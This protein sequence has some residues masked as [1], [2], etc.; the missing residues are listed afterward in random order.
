[1]T[2]SGVRIPLAA[3]NSHLAEK[4]GSPKTLRV[5]KSIAALA[6]FIDVN[7]SSF[8]R[9]VVEV[10]VW[11]MGG[12]SLPPSDA[13][14]KSVTDFP[15]P[16]PASLRLR[17]ALALPLYAASLVLDYASAALGQLAAWVAGDDWPG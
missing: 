8:D 1:M 17:R 11:Q 9:G 13:A 16:V 7:A 10:L 2:G 12:I 14:T 6:L 15:K 3:P 5:G 4:A